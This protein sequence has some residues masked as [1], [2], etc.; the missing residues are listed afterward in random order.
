MKL[1]ITFLYLSASCVLAQSG[2]VHH[3]GTVTLYWESE[4][5]K[6]TPVAAQPERAV[7]IAS[8]TIAISA[9]KVGILIDDK[10]A[11]AY[12]V[13]IHFKSGGSLTD[14]L[15]VDSS[16]DPDYTHYQYVVFIG[17]KVSE[18]VSVTVVKSTSNERVSASA[19]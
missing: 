2:I 17:S 18:V 15:I 8:G 3:I 1:L 14:T 6:I 13:T 10:S 19:A 11:M 9:T 12:E 7:K 5:V 16:L 4:Q